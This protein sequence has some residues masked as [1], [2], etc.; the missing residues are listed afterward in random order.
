MLQDL[1]FVAQVNLYFG[2]ESY[3]TC[4]ELGNH[5]IGKLEYLCDRTVTVLLAHKIRRKITYS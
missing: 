3:T 4:L 2:Y 1:G 5:H